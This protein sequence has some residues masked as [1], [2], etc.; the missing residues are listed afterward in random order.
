[1]LDYGHVMELLTKL[2]HS[3]DE[4]VLLVSRDNTTQLVLCYRDVRRCIDNAIRDLMYK[5][6]SLGG[7]DGANVGGQGWED[8]SGGAY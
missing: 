3:S 5:K 1:M 4:Y 6:L 2:D 8:G 7:Y